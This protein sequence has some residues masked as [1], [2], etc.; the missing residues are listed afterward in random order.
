MVC[1]ATSSGDLDAVSTRRDDCRLKMTGSRPSHPGV[2]MFRMHRRAR[3]ALLPLVLAAT[4]TAFTAGTGV[5]AA[6][7]P[8]LTVRVKQRTLVVEGGRAD[9]VIQLFS[10]A[11]TP[12]NVVVALGLEDPRVVATVHRDRFDAVV[13]RAGDGDDHILVDETSG[14]SVPFTDGEADHAARRRRQRHRGRRK[15]RRAAER[16]RRLRHRR[17]QR[18]RRRHQPR[19]RQRPGDLGSGRRQRH[20]RGRRRRRRDVVQRR[21]DQ[22]VL[23][24]QPPTASGCASP[25]SRATS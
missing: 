6:P 11:A 3:R 4:A 21:A 20:R 23:R 8:K 1:R 16:R 24:R 19:R 13:V 7:G 25:E 2:E 14:A 15:R 10:P 5:D 9:E 18:R 17:R 12:F 22:R